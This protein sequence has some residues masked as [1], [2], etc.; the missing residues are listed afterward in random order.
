MQPP[1]L[2]STR[3]RV[4]PLLQPPPVDAVIG[5]LKDIS[6]LRYEYPWYAGWDVD[7]MVAGGYGAARYYISYFTTDACR[8]VEEHGFIEDKRFGKCEALQSVDVAL[9][10]LTIAEILPQ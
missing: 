1:F 2:N 7:C 5:I 6:T 3:K 8:V 10:V 4:L 9:D